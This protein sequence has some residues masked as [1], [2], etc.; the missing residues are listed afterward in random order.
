MLMEDD[1]DLLH[2]LGFGKDAVDDNGMFETDTLKELTQFCDTHPEYH[3]VTMV[4]GDGGWV[5]LNRVA[6][7]NRLAYYLANGD[8]DDTLF[9]E[10]ESDDDDDDLRSEENYLLYWSEELRAM[11][12]AWTGEESAED[13]RK[14]TE[15]LERIVP[16]WCELHKDNL[17][18]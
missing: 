5:Y 14:I 17:T 6:F 13:R 7:V 8:K 3:I 10:A 18:A 16:G 9:A 11:A 12:E 1:L 15:Q 2:S 4:R